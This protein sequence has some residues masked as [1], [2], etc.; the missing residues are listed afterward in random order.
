MRKL[1]QAALLA[2]VLA[3]VWYGIWSWQMAGDVARVKASISYQYTHLRERNQTTSLEA[4]EVFATGF[5]FRY[6]I[7]IK[8]PTLSMVDGDETFAVSIPFVT[9]ELVDRAQGTYRVDLPASVQALYAKNGRAPEHYDVTP[10]TMPEVHLSAADA[11]K[12]CG[13]MIGAPCP[14]V[15]KDAPLISYQVNMPKTLMLH[16][17]LGDEAKD[18]SFGP[19]LLSAPVNRPI[20]QD[21]SG[22]LQLFIG[23]LREALVFHTK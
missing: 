17:Q 11:S 16:M 6:G 7:G 9:L 18:A 5:P 19:F 15:A 14:D 23:I 12:P 2:L 10:D 21:M 22:P 20:P 1:L 3:G 4:D 13:F 8:R